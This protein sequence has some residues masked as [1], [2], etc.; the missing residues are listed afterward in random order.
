MRQSIMVHFSMVVALVGIGFG[1]ADLKE[2]T[3]RA[4]K[5]DAQAQFDLGLRLHQGNGVPKDDA[6]ALQWFL[7]AAAQDN[8]RAAVQ[9]GSIYA[10]G[11]GVKVDWAESIRWYRQAALAGDRVA[12]HNLGLD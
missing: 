10:H 8:P 6:A 9:L 3:A 11:F 1:Q 2:L 12:Q 4:E 5:G 7:K